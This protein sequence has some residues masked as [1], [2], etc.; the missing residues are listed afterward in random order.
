PKVTHLS[1]LNLDVQKANRPQQLP[2]SPSIAVSKNH[3][4][5]NDPYALYP[6]QAT[7]PTPKVQPK[8][9]HKP[10]KSTQTK[11]SVPQRVQTWANST[12]NDKTNPFIQTSQPITTQPK[13]IPGNLS[14]PPVVQQSSPF[15]V[16]EQSGQITVQI[17]RSKLLRTE[18][19]V[20]RTAVVDPMICEIAQFSPNE[21]SVIGKQEGATSVTFWIEGRERP[22]TYLVEVTPDLQ[23][24][25]QREVQ[26]LMLEE[27]LAKLFP[28]SK[29]RLIPVANKLIVQG[30]ARDIDEATKIMSIIRDNAQQAGNQENEF[31]FDDGTA[32]S[33]MV[34]SDNGTPTRIGPRIINMLNIPGVQQVAL[35]V[36]I[37]E[38]NRSAARGFGLDVDAEINFSSKSGS[39][40]FVESMLN[41]AAGSAPA[42]VGRFDGDDINLGLRYLQQQGV[43]RVLAEP[44]LV[45]MS[46]KEASFL[47]GG[48]IAIPTAVGNIGNNAITTD[49][50]PFGVLVNFMPTVIDKDRIR[51]EVSP[52]FS[53]INRDNAVAGTPGFDVRAVSTTVEMREG[54]TLA[55]AGLLEDNMKATTVSDLPIL[56]QIFG[57]RDVTRDETELVIIIT[58]ELVQPMEPEG[59]PPLPG[60]DVTE[61]NN[62]EF[63]L[64]NRLEGIPTRNYRSTVYPR[65]QNRYRSGGTPVIGGPF[66][67]GK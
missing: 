14:Q 63:F 31:S 21:I 37:A 61:P 7:Q 46:G 58:P 47:A 52:E 67:H 45:T 40:M 25:K 13:T 12:R 49:F 29:V 32:A 16:I 9:Q 8:I 43:V 56:T 11:P 64:Q 1:D 50:K 60:F 23:L 26:Y 39:A 22:I 34:T 30:Q 54:Q 57:K 42:L 55:I 2:T 44:T 53:Q 38:L 5:S 51:L 24:Q 15:E 66:G 6:T 18:G 19:K 10:L 17:R 20:Y 65:L 62:S 48:E 59:V 41:L 36:K 4:K 27:I 28:N 3:E 35:R 33:V